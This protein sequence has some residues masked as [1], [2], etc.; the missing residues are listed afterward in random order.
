MCAVE[1]AK[2]LPLA[3]HGRV[4]INHTPKT[5]RWEDSTHFAVKPQ[6]NSWSHRQEG[7]GYKIQKISSVGGAGGQ[8]TLEQ[9]LAV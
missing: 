9:R 8:I 6:Y 4:F 3:R 2:S 1:M 5:S 7:N